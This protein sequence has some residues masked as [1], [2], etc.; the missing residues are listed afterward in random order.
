MDRVNYWKM[1]TNKKDMLIYLLFS[2]YIFLITFSKT[3]WYTTGE[4]TMFFNGLKL[5]RYMFYLFFALFFLIN[6]IK[7]KYSKESWFF[8]LLLLVFDCSLFCMFLWNVRRKNNKVFFN[9]TRGGT[10]NYGSICFFRVC[11]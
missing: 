1:K 3:A 2:V 11:G 6:T 8:I 7:K 4:G 10:V 9:Y 5:I